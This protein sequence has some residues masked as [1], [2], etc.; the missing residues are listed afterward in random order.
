M[1]FVPNWRPLRLDDNLRG[2]LCRYTGKGRIQTS[3]GK[4][5]RENLHRLE[6]WQTCRWG[7]D[8]CGDIEGAVT[9]ICLRSFS[10]RSSQPSNTRFRGHSFSD[11]VDIRLDERLNKK[12]QSY[13]TNVFIISEGQP[14][15]YTLISFSHWF[16]EWSVRMGRDRY[17]FLALNIFQ[18]N[19]RF[20]YW[21]S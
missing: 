3:P 15:I 1:R 2:I 11:T 20:S 13:S 7:S 21:T 12:D 4:D 8:R 5:N 17:F 16:I 10:A 9:L 18:Q 19:Y 14:C 6:P